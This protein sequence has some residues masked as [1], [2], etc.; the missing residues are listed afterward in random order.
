MRSNVR[1][2]NHSWNSR[3]LKTPG[4]KIATVIPCPSFPMTTS[5]Y[6]LME[7]GLTISCLWTDDGRFHATGSPYW[8]PNEYT[9]TFTCDLFI[10]NESITD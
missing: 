5:F 9:R 6:I 2:S 3:I 1:E 7:G 8:L 4:S 10:V